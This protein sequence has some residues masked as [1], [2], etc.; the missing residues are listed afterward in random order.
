MRIYIG[1]LSEVI[2]NNHLKEA[3][4]DYGKVTNAKVIFDK[5]SG[6]SRGFGFVEMP[7]DEEA[8]NAI[9]TLNGGRWEGKVLVIRK[10][11]PK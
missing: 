4:E 11:H 5:E 3:F 2:R 1:N 8:Q 9:R 10:A 7:N 6:R